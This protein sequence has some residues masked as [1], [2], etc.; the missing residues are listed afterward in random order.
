MDKMRTNYGRTGGQQRQMNT[1]LH[2]EEV[3]YTCTRPPHHSTHRTRNTHACRQTSQTYTKPS[4][5]KHTHTPTN[6]H[7]HLD[8]HTH[9]STHIHTQTDK[10]LPKD[11]M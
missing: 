2:P 1:L 3:T 8:T 5:Y 7:T 11:E 9:T 6:T 4:A 10:P